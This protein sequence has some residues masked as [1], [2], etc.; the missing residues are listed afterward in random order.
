MIGTL[1]VQFWTAWLTSSAA[2]WTGGSVVSENSDVLLKASVAVALT[3]GGWASGPEVA[4][5]LA[6]GGRPESVR[7]K[8]PLASGVA[9]P[10]ETSPWPCVDGSW[11]ELAKRSTDAVL[12]LGVS[13]RPRIVV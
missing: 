11:I 6:K 10:R 9:V 7:Q 12:A 1:L 4:G 3:N 13:R 5:W 2:N 8:E